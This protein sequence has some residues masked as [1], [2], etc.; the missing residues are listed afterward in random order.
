MDILTSLGFA[1]QKEEIRS[2]LEEAAVGCVTITEVPLALTFYDPMNIHVENYLFNWCFSNT[3]RVGTVVC[4]RC[5][6]VNETKIVPFSD[7]TVH[8]G[9]YK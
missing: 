2:G 3:S 8:W 9:R 6:V 4:T 1:S 5:T 7:Y